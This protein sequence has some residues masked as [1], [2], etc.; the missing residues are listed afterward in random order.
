MLK[1]PVDERLEA[2]GHEFIKSDQYM[3]WGEGARALR[4][5]K[6]D[7]NIARLKGL[8]DDPG[9]SYLHHPDQ[10]DGLEV[11]LYGVRDDAFQ[12]LK[13]WEVDVPKPVIRE[14]IQR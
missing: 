6:S 14:E 11:R 4:Y 8:L 3:R 9:W 1:V 12:T 10:N 13:S 7:E 5:F 2:R